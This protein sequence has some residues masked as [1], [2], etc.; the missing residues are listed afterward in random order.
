MSSAPLS[1]EKPMKS[2]AIPPRETVIKKT[3]ISYGRLTHF[4]FGKAKYIGEYKHGSSTVKSRKGSSK[5]AENFA[6]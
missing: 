2:P 3:A 4:G 1:K 6:K 5:R